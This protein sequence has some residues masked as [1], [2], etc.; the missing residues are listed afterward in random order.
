MR[1]EALGL[2]WAPLALGCQG[3]LG[4]TQDTVVELPVG[5][6][7]SVPSDA[8]VDGGVEYR[9]LTRLANWSSFD[10]TTVSPKSKSFLG[11]TFDGHHVY[12][13]PSSGSL[14]TRYDVQ[15]PFGQPSSWSTFNA[16]LGGASVAGGG[17]AFDGRFVYFIAGSAVAQYDSHA[18]FEEPSSWTNVDVA[19]LAAEG[20]LNASSASWVSPSLPSFVGATFDG[21]F[22]Y[23]APSLGTVIVRFDTT[24]YLTDPESW[25]AYDSAT[26]G[27]SFRVSTGA[28]QGSIFDGRYVYFVP[29][30]TLPVVRYNTEIDFADQAAWSAF[31]TGSLELGTDDFRCGAYDGRY[32]YLAPSGTSLAVQ[33]DTSKS[34]SMRHSWS[35]F[36]TTT[37]NA[38]AAGFGG[39]A[40]DGRYVYFIPGDTSFIARFDAEL[41][42]TSP[43]AWE[44]FNT[45]PVSDSSRSFGGAIFDGQYVYLVPT[46]G[47]SIVRFDARTPPSLPSLPESSGSFL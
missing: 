36:D 12:L 8:S 16:G 4:L 33:Y 23:L 24:Q 5:T 2:F 18:S 30:G 25:E 45:L 19:Q 11:G 40:F 41:D 46:H 44:V 20:L 43:Q 13:A 7:A 38:S 28:Y 31:D 35:I 22:L 26:L 15:A 39:S 6:D 9:A 42:F 10:T 17:A 29:G 47:G 14:V 3:V 1:L 32:L 27:I 21:R 37:V 34:F